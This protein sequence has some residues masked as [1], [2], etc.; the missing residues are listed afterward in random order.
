MQFDA[1]INLFQL[2]GSSAPLECAFQF[3]S[4]ENEIF[5]LSNA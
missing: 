4:Y 5:C 3:K 2:M 1:H